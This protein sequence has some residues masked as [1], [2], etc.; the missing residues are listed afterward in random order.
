MKQHTLLIATSLFTMLLFT[1]HWADDI[2]R[3]LSPGTMSGLGGVAIMVVWL[4]GTLL[5][6]ERRGG[7][8]IMLLAS[9]LAVGVLAIHMNG[10]GLVG[11]RVAL[12]NGVLL[13]VWTLIT[14][15]IS[16]SFAAILSARAL[17]RSWHPAPKAASGHVSS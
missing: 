13:W 17:W 5:L 10:N 15:G 6:T 1:V 8:I 2:V 4:C 9:L 14:L 11:G 12:T 16:G 3:G 7:Q